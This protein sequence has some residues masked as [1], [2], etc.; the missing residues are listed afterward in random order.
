M[1]KSTKRMHNPSCLL[2]NPRHL[3]NHKPGQNQ[4]VTT[5]RCIL[6]VIDLLGTVNLLIFKGSL[7]R[8]SHQ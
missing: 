3:K 4:L 5:K 7:S 2:A 8:R 1:K 6:N